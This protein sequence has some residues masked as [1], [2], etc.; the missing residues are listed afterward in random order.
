MWTGIGQGTILRYRKADALVSHMIRLK[1]RCF[2]CLLY[3][4]NNVM[5][6]GKNRLRSFYFGNEFLY[7][8]GSLLIVR[9]V[10]AVDIYGIKYIRR[11]Q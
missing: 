10:I 9:E 1:Y 4:D 7:Y 11:M 8:Y 3:K 2:K 5:I 6:S